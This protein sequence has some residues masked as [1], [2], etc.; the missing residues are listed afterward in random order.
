MR[1]IKWAAS[2]SSWKRDNIIET[3]MLISW[4]Y[5]EVFV[6][7]EFWPHGFFSMKRGYRTGSKELGLS[8]FQILFEPFPL[9][10]TIYHMFKIKSL[11]LNSI[12]TARVHQKI[13][14]FFLKLIA[15]SRIWNRLLK[16]SRRLEANIKMES[17]QNLD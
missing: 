8:L 9:K 16:Y 17:S 10:R 15:F 5:W 2:S 1:Q 3:N 12:W 14:S 4:N 6:C 7:V 11:I 13:F